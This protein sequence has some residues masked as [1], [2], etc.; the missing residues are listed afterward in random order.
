MLLDRTMVDYV[1]E[2]PPE[3]HLFTFANP[4]YDGTL[5]GN[6]KAPSTVVKP[7]R[8]LQKKVRSPPARTLL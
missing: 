7:V 8:D 2:C 1:V 6:L 5:S 4:T 3:K